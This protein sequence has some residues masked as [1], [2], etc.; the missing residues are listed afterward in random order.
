MKVQSEAIWSVVVSVLRAR[1]TVHKVT[2]EPA[3]AG[4]HGRCGWLR[5][6]LCFA[7]IVTQVADA[8]LQKLARACGDKN[9]SAAARRIKL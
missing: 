2:L 1:S 7:P 5:P 8:L 9:R 3:E 6:P 4:P